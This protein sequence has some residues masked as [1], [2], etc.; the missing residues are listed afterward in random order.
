MRMSQEMKFKEKTQGS[1]YQQNQH[2]HSPKQPHQQQRKLSTRQVKASEARDED[3]VRRTGSS[4]STSSDAHKD[5]TRESA[6]R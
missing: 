4:P 2:V 6:K 1:I 5:N 3:Q